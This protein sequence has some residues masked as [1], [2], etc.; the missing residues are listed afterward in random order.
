[1]ISSKELTKAFD[2][3][4]GISADV[5]IDNIYSS[6]KLGR[7]LDMAGKLMRRGQSQRGRGF[8]QDF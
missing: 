5:N 4:E 3:A 2:E 1:M 8:P 6:E 7:I